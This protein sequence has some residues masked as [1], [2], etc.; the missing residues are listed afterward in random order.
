MG[1]QILNS[2]AK[3]RSLF[4]RSLSSVLLLQSCLRS[5]NQQKKQLRTALKKSRAQAVF[6]ASKS[7]HVLYPTFV[8]ATPFT[9]PTLQEKCRVRVCACRPKSIGGCSNRQPS[10]STRNA[11]L[12]LII[13]STNVRYS[14]P[15]HATS[16]PA[17]KRG[18]PV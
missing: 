16:L 4:G 10:T 18:F 15:F 5:A 2:R 6:Y 8:G 17:P 9:T 13:C 14:L 1:I 7:P 12:N 11:T 3:K